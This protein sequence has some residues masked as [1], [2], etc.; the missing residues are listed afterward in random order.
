[1][2]KINLYRPSLFIVSITDAS[3]L[4]EAMFGGCSGPTRRVLYPYPRRP[5]AFISTDSSPR[6]A[7]ITDRAHPRQVELTVRSPSQVHSE[8]MR[9]IFLHLYP[10]SLSSFLC[11]DVTFLIWVFPMSI[12][13]ES[14]SERGRSVLGVRGSLY[15]RPRVACRSFVGHPRLNRS[16]S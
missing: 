10:F 16:M 3:R 9:G 8:H 13:S 1:M 11:G 7:G 12:A 15:R 14:P 6:P 5:R 4:I 2:I